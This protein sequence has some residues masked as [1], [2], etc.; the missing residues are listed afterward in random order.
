MSARFNFSPVSSSDSA[1][2]TL[3]AGWFIIN[4][5]VYGLLVV[6]AVVAML[7]GNIS[8]ATN[9]VFVRVFV[10]ALA[11]AGIVWAGILL[12]RRNRLGG[13]L[14]FGLILL[15]IIVSLIARQPMD[16]TEIVFS[17][18][19]IIVLSLIW[20]ELRAQPRIQ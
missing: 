5:A 16:M 17:V 12:G 10:N 7:L 3:A 19:G 13:F 9:W 15:P 8:V 2:L 4:G 1:L 6:I 18:L 11:A 14:A 20:H